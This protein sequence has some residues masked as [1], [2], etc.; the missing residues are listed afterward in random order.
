MM[1]IWFI[2]LVP[3]FIMMMVLGN[4]WSEEE[5]EEV[6]SGTYRGEEGEEEEEEERKKR[7]MKMRVM[8]VM[9][10]IPKR[11]EHPCGNMSQSLEEGQGVEPPNLYAPIVTKLTRVHISL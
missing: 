8:A 7:M 4:W 9:E 3:F 6:G 5:D 10:R 1:G 2:L 11:T